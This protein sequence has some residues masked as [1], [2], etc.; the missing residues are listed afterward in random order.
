MALFALRKLRLDWVWWLV[1]P[2]NPLK[3]ARDYSDYGQ[4]LGLTRKIARHPRFIVTD[5]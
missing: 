1:A 3:D 5:I 2:Q 4:R